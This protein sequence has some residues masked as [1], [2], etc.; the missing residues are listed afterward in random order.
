[1]SSRHRHAA[2]SYYHDLIEHGR[3]FR[4]G[5]HLPRHWHVARWVC[6]ALILPCAVCAV[7]GAVLA[8]RLAHGPLEVTRVSHLLG[9]VPVVGGRVPG[10]PAGQLAWERLFLQWQP[11]RDGVPAGIMLEAHGLTVRGLDGRVAESAGE[12]D[13]VLS[14]APL[15]HGVIAPRR[16]RLQHTHIALRSMPGGALELDLPQQG[17]SGR[18]VPTQLDRLG[19]LDIHDVTVS[20]AGLLPGQMVALGPVEAHGICRALSGGGCAWV[21]RWAS[22][23]H[24]G[25][26]SSDL[27]AE[28]V[29]QGQMG[30]WHF[31]MTPIA[32]SPIGSLFPFAGQWKLPVSLEGDALLVSRGFEARPA[33]LALTVQL[34][35][36]Q[37]EQVQGD[38]IH[39]VNG[40][41]H[42]VLA[43]DKPGFSGGIK[44]EITDAAIAVQDSVGHVTHVTAAG[45]LIADN[46]RD[47]VHLDGQAHAQ[48]DALD[49]EHLGTI[50]PLRFIKGARQ[51][52]TRNLTYG[53]GHALT[54]VSHVH[55]DRG[56]DGLRP[57]VME[58]RF[59][60][61][62]V[63]VNW[64]RP[65][66]PAEH[67]AASLHFDGPE[68]LVIDFAH[69][70]Q[71]TSAGVVTIPDGSVRI[72]HLYDRGPPAT[73]AVHVAGPVAGVQNILSHPRLH[74]LAKHP[75]PFTEYA[76]AMDGHLMLTMPLLPNV[77][78]D[79][80][81]V[82]VQASFRDVALG[83]VLLGRRL[84]GAKGT[85]QADENRLTVNGAGR[86]SGVPVQAQV[87]EVFRAAGAQ[88]VMQDITAHALFTPQ[89]AVQAG[90]NIPG[91]VAGQS[92]LQAHYIQTA[93]HQADIRLGLD[94][95][96]A[97]VDLPIWSKPVGD[98]AQV[99]A[100]MVLSGNEMTVLDGLQA[101]GQG[102]DV[103]GRA[104]TDHGRLSRVVLE[105]FRVGRTLGD[106]QVDFPEG[107][108]PMRVHVHADPLDITPLL[109]RLNDRSEHHAEC[110]SCTARREVHDGWSVVLEAPHVYYS[111]RG[112]LSGVQAQ[113]E[114]RDGQLR[115]A[116]FAMET[117][118]RVRGVLA[119]AGTEQPLV[120]DID[121]LGGLLSGL[122]LFDRISGGVTHL[123][124]RFK[125]GDRVSGSAGVGLGL[126][127]FTG[128]VDVGT[129]DVL[130]PPL[131]VTVA[132]DLSP[133]HWASTRVDRF[134]IQHFTSSLALSDGQ[135]MLRDGA[136]GN[137]ALGATLEGQ[138]GVNDTALVLDGTIVPL[139]GLNALP[140]HLPGIGHLLSPEKNGGL[141]AATFRVGGHLSDPAL[142]INPFSMLLPGALRKLVH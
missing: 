93:D 50:W 84:D 74:L 138:I 83:H 130:K 25:E 136:I 54:L 73:I 127:P 51:W 30:A 28:G 135:V 19:V 21:G 97:K 106:A 72:E 117:P 105:G 40:G 95:A 71:V 35:D 52:V 99:S 137:T 9:P 126:P 17:H 69:G 16:L 14:L 123:D 22:T 110:A 32:P 7:V 107:E 41:A 43:M 86:L 111:A 15:L 77:R 87:L 20:V 124:G 70:Q 5:V 34:G 125:S 58:G 81:H 68:T 37:V 38:P 129:F 60:A 10:H 102:L 131:G 64:L 112:M 3:R 62:D 49:L 119:D 53:Q 63:T 89:Q 26:V 98:A 140:G 8:W 79:A 13:T 4:G 120:L 103:A 6:L 121:N 48:I 56:L 24:V 45:V 96:P 92:V 44:A 23:L 78:D 61:D 36:G 141:L 100:H 29:K 142:T 80:M 12:V 66:P 1:M 118:S 31:A 85:L 65:V 116:R 134:T 27:H 2:H 75:L 114:L 33:R 11:A 91:F 113:M 55:S 132:S 76:G 39:V 101:H 108:A 94:L 139:F 104:F 115:S 133:L 88:S 18:G 67:V 59:A 57:T 82:G 109:T 42:L 47:P 122:G 90:V 128:H 46:V